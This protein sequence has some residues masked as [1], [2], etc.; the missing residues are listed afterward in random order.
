MILAITNL[1]RRKQGLSESDQPSVRASCDTASVQPG[2]VDS[3]VV[4]LRFERPK[5]SADMHVS[6]LH[7]FKEH[8]LVVVGTKGSI[9]FD[10]TK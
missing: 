1:L 2:I 4:S 7:P 10:D 9:V 3:A 5:F 8:K 6:W